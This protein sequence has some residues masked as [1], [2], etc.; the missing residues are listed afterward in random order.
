MCFTSEAPRTS[1]VTW[2]GQKPFDIH[3]AVQHY[4]W[5]SEK[6]LP[7]SL[8]NST[9]HDNDSNRAANVARTR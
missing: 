3:V 9:G 5:N 4:I 7:A 8:N 6:D 2:K 1:E